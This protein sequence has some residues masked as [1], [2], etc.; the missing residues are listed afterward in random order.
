L[1]TSGLDARRD[2]TVSEISLLVESLGA[3][4]AWRKEPPQIRSEQR[5]IVEGQLNR[6]D[7]GR[8]SENGPR[9][10]CVG[11]GNFARKWQGRVAGGNAER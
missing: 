5:R 6:R 11:T 10:T 3:G 2:P 1:T 9:D 8:R 7:G 4:N